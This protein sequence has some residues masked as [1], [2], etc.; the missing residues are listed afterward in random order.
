MATL[1]L[2]SVPRAILT[3]PS[4]RPSQALAS[5]CAAHLLVAFGEQ[6]ARY[7]AA[8]ELPKYAGIAPVTTRSGKKSWVPWRLQGPK[9]LRHT[10][11]EGT[12][13]SIRHSFW[14]QVD[15]QQQ[16]DKG[17]THQAAV[18]ALAFKWSRSLVRCW[19]DRTP[20]DESTYL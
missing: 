17:K 16:R 2:P 15:Y 20:Y 8:T 14:A 13:E 9:F 12:A 11:V 1:P 4:A 5:V 19:Q 3:S 7:A 6:H 10:F 18:R